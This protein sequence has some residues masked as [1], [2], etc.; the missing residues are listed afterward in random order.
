MRFIRL[1][2][3][4]AFLVTTPLFADRTTINFD[5]DWRFFRGE[6]PAPAP[7]QP[8]SGNYAPIDPASFA[9]KDDSWR[10]V[11]VPH[12]WS[13][14]GPFDEKAATNAA[15]GFL[16]SGVAWYRKTFTVPGDAKGKR[17]FIEFDGVMANSEVYL[18]KSLLG[19]RPNGYVP[20]R[21]DMTDAINW[22]GPNLIAVRTDT[23]R[24]PASRWYTG[25][26]INR[27]VRMVV[28]E[29]V[30]L[31]YGATTVTASRPTPDA[32]GRVS[33]TVQVKTII[34]N[35]SAA[36]QEVRVQSSARGPKGDLATSNEASAT[37]DAGKSLSVTQEIQVQNPE[38]WNPESPA[39]YRLSTTVK[40]NGVVL[41]HDEADFGIR[42]T[43]FK[44]DTG[45]WLNGKNIKLLGV[46]L[47][48][49]AGAL[50]TAV[51]AS[52]WE[53]RL[54]ELKKR[55]VNAVR[56]AHNP[57]P[58]EFYDVCDR[59]GILVMD[60]AFDVWTVAKEPGDYHLYFKDWWQ[61]DLEAMVKAH[62]NHP[63]IV[64]WSL[65]N[66]IWDILPQNPDPAADQFIG[67]NRSIDLAKGIFG[68]MKELAHQLD[69]T[70]PVTIAEMRANV[71]KAYDNGFAD[72]MDVIGQNYRD[73]E[74]AA[75]HKQNP[76]R[77]IIGTENYKTR[78]TWLALRDNPALSG[79]FLWAG[80]DYLG[81]SGA[82]PNVVS[83]SGILDRT[84]MPRGEALEREAWWSS[85]PVVH[86]ARMQLMP[87]RPGR[88]AVT[89]GF[90]DWTPA[91]ADA[92]E[93]TVSV[94]SNCEAVEL[95]LNDKSLGSKPKDAGDA[96][97]Q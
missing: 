43:E 72:M 6:P 29:A 81:E 89:M 66:E 21:Y 48:S 39:M 60:E 45:F 23:S 87:T 2:A 57:M 59:M 27:H 71:A 74:L 56:T 28:Q 64:I 51:P 68:P 1:A 84:N 17:V 8:L 67:P 25:A 85:K 90:A 91:N 24:Q 4:T 3:L 42:I 73:N 80:V 88:P 76:Q 38:L 79:Q 86:I 65:G 93:E 78:E 16:P 31:A 33:S 97:R 77:K 35:E 70:R 52:A 32:M 55:G 40:Q 44:A 34:V 7:A 92:H 96:P 94:Y 12:D 26:G 54:A 47:H 10:K 14:E 41:D 46:A 61:R 5:K 53:S 9:M 13:I 30:H 36:A 62:R 95:F 15:G 37:L 83:P 63:S 50:G 22:D 11:D 49:D 18:N 19:S 58:P 82:W 75:A 69:P 20:F